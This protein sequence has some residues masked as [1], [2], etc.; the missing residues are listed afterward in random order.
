MKQYTKRSM[1][2]TTVRVA[3]DEADRFLAAATLEGISRSEFLRRSIHE[4]TE[5]VLAR[6]AQQRSAEK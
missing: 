1:K 4:R 5:K 3:A 2:L 6:A